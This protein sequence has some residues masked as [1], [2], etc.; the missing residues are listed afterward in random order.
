MDSV[1][2]NWMQ[3]LE[4]AE[5]QQ[6]IRLVDAFTG[7]WSSTGAEVSFLCQQLQASV[8]PGCT[9]VSQITDTGLAAPAKAAAQQQKEKLRELLRLK[10][11]QEGVP[12]RY[13][14]GLREIL[15]VAVSMHQRMVQENH[16]SQAVLREF[17][18]CGWGA[19]RP[20][21][22][23]LVSSNCQTW[24]QPFPESSS[25]IRASCREE[26]LS[27]L[28]EAGKPQMLLWHD[29]CE[30]QAEQPAGKP[31]P[32]QP[33]EL[34]VSYDRPEQALQLDLDQG[35]LNDAEERAAQALLLHPSKRSAEQQYLAELAMLPSQAPPV[36][37]A[38]KPE[39]A[40]PG[41]KPGK[42][43]RAKV[44]RAD[45]GRKTVAARLLQIKPLVASAGAALPGSQKKA[46]KRTKEHGSKKH[47][48]LS[49]ARKAA[50]RKM[51]EKRQKAK[52]AAEAAEAAA[53]PMAGSLVRLT[54][55]SVS[56]LHWNLTARCLK[57]WQ[58]E[59]EVLVQGP[60]SSQLRLKA[61]AVYELNSKEAGQLA[62]PDILGL[63]TVTDAE[64]Q[65]ACTAAGGQIRLLQPGAQMEAPEMTACWHEVMARARRAK[66]ELQPGEVSFLDPQASIQHSS[67][68]HFR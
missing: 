4:A 10:A 28:D 40:D 3:R 58:A 67:S 37:A 32:L 45:L 16:R 68:M 57:H 27:W 36:P 51:K 39:K 50:R 26:R 31:I 56:K 17:R 18:Q 38:H 20:Q 24:A 5:H 64:K 65:A 33:A 9:A 11:R 46:K 12:A 41:P 48:S 14:V 15:S 62:M 44:F 2:F 60:G 21:G 53:G 34:E 42:A 59:G 54:G 63:R 22:G 1:L 35:W 52:A 29:S 43:E 8:A 66:D 61:L 49:V 6:L 30:E 7:G 13:K 23:S 19:W 47:G 25:K 55:Q